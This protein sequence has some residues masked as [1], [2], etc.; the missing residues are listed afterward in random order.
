MKD[1]QK[2]YKII[3]NHL[4]KL[5]LMV[6]KSRVFRQRNGFTWAR[7][8]LVIEAT[9]EAKKS[10]IKWIDYNIQKCNNKVKT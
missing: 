2:S 8:S 3:L 6:S 1:W 5:S 10:L 4:R 9:A 7:R